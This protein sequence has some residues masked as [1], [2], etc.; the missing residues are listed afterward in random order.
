MAG[1]DPEIATVSDSE[2][3][4]SDDEELKRVL[5]MSIHDVGGVGTSS[6]SKDDEE[7]MKRVL[8]ISLLPEQPL[9]KLTGTMVAT[10]DNDDDEEDSEA[11]LE[12]ALRRSLLDMGNVKKNSGKR[13]ETGKLNIKS[14]RKKTKVKHFKCDAKDIEDDLATLEEN[15]CIESDRG[16]ED[17]KSDDSI[18]KDLQEIEAIG[19]IDDSDSYSSENVSKD[20]GV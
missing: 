15:G 20:D 12:E 8:D 1:Q 2:E 3:D 16:T 11:E 5:E 10:K 9:I 17:Q 19:M 13:V 6:Q 14:K 7:E 18:T 4:E